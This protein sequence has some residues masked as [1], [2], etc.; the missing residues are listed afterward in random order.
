VLTRNQLLEIARRDENGAF[1]VPLQRL[2]QVTAELQDSVMKTRMQ[3]IGNAWTKLPRL[4]RDLCEELGKEIDV[5]TRGAE[6]EIDRQLLDMVRDPMVHIIR[7]A[8]QGHCVGG[9]GRRF[10]HAVH[11]R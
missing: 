8:R 6:T 1:K 11:R 5:E 4:V 10:H 3:P 7:N 2:S 9:T